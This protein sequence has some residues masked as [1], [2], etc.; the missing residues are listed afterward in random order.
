MSD[1]MPSSALHDS[2]DF[3][4]PWLWQRLRSPLVVSLFLATCVALLFFIAEHNVEMSKSENFVENIEKQEGW[5]AGGNKLRQLAFLGC[6]AIGAVSLL[7]GRV[8]K[9]RLTL[10]VLLIACY[11]IWAGASVTWSIDSGT[12]VRR[13]MVMICCL[14]GC[15]GF[16]RFLRVQDVVLAA[17]LV[18]LSY[19]VLGVGAEVLLGTFRPHV[20]EYRFAG[21][22]HPNIQAANLAMGS[23]AA[24]TM[25][26]V[27]PDLKYAFYGV[28]GLLFLFLILTK[29][30]SATGTVPV[31]LGVIWLASQPTRNIVV[32]ALACGW[33]VSLIVLACMVSGFDPISEYQ[34]VLLMGRGEETGSSLTGRLPLWQDLT[35]YIS[36]K[37]W[38]GFG[39]GAFWTPRHIYEIAVSQQWVISE[40][41]SSYVE[42]TLHLGI[43]GAVLLSITMISTLFYTVIVFRK[44]MSR[45]EYLFIVGGVF[46]CMIRGFTESGLTA[47]ASVTSFLFIA[48]AAHSWNG[49]KNLTNSEGN[50]P[51]DLRR[52]S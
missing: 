45:P 1:V 26:R 7:L 42:A 50:V 40:A 16:S 51:N 3:S 19:L 36:Y 23:L 37:P 31:A 25:A 46:F 6:A 12:T 8:G 35:V 5:A 30:R 10:P 15:F 44:T 24:F 34:E 4:L 11:V 48:V 14:V 27:K 18:S 22:L 47:P 49:R 2:E 39:Y 21:T 38:K 17:V 32:G 52:L 33:V 20:G 28:F 41:H 43:I 29:C 13:Y 9:F